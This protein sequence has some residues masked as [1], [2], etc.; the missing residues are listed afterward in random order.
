MYI[1][2]KE[3]KKALHFILFLGISVSLFLY[4]FR[5]EVY[6]GG[7]DNY[8][9]YFISKYS[10]LYPKLFL[11]HWGK[12]LFTLLTS[13]FAQLGIRGI[14]FFNILLGVFT[15]F[16][17]N[18]LLKELRFQ[19]RY[20]AL[21]FLLFSPIYFALL[22]SA[23]TE[24]LAGFLLTLFLL[25]LAK[26]RYHLAAIIFSS[27]VLVRTETYIFYPL[28]IIYF[29]LLKKYLEI[30]LTFLFPVL[31]SLIG[32]FVYN[33][34]FWLITHNPYAGA[35][36]VYG[37]GSPFHFLLKS[38][39]IFGWPFLIFTIF[40]L[41]STFY[42]LIFK[43]FTEI[44]KKYTLLL[45]HFLW[46]SLFA[47][48]SVAYWMGNKASLGL[49][50]VLVPILPL[51]AVSA[52]IGFEFIYL[53]VIE[54]PIF[55]QKIFKYIIIFL[56]IAMQIIQPWIQLPIPYK[57]NES[58]KVLISALD[59]IK[60]KNILNQKIFYFDVFV[61][62]YLNL[63]PFDTLS[64]QEGIK[65]KKYPEYETKIGDVI[66]YDTRYAPIEGGVLLE[67]FMK[68]PHFKLINYFA[69]IVEEKTL[70]ERLYEVYIFSRIEKIN[71]L[72]EQVLDSIK[73]AKYQNAFYL[74]VPDS[75]VI[76]DNSEF[77]DI[78][79][80]ELNQ[81]VRIELKNILHISFDL[82]H[83]SGDLSNVGL[84]MSF[85]NQDS[86]VAFFSVP[87]HHFL[88]RKSFD[89][90]IRSIDANRLKIF[91]WNMDKNPISVKVENISVYLAEKVY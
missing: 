68:N 56:T 34:L 49:I 85:E 90:F 50:R 84:C 35:S 54:I 61:P 45:I 64:N 8:A 20:P 78:C 77:V 16:V 27:L 11:D 19:T 44:E 23:M 32:Y 31:Y 69:P 21:I 70:H 33:D 15:L 1:K 38:P 48:H 57:F 37:S 66:V 46:L 67:T 24:I 60:R 29:L 73:A 83:L 74:S 42:Q 13:P 80:I 18:K 51:S 71:E 55:K 58:D 17:L 14:V 47:A 40:G 39:E 91:I 79:S 4:S 26:K 86:I 36:D 9:H 88:E 22:M 53:R 43:K 81:K 63:N 65:N 87:I 7:R 72:T 28:V 10:W 82:T 5:F 75:I 12:P 59:W 52:A 62:Y 76:Q 25:F 3:I 30:F 2:S 89:Q 6:E 41:V